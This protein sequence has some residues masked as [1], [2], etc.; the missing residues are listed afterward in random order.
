MIQTLVTGGT[1]FVGHSI[2]RELVKN[3]ESV[4]VLSRDPLKVDRARRVSGAHYIQGNVF[5]PKSL[6]RAMEGCD[7]LINCVQFENA[8]FENPKKGLTYEKVDGEGSLNQ[9][10]AIK[11]SSIERVIYMS[12]A[13]VKDG[14]IEP[15]FK[16]KL[17]AEEAVKNCGKNWTIFRPSWI[18]GAQDNSLNKFA[19]FARFSPVVPLIGMGNE[20]IQPIYVEDVAKCVAKA[21][22]TKSTF[23]EIIELG[24]QEEV[25]MKKIVQT[26]L[27]VKG[28]KRILLPHPKPLMKLIASVVQ[29]LPGRMLTPDAIDFITMEEK[30]DVSNLTR[31]LGITPLSLKEGLK[32]Y[33]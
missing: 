11:G 3:N 26:L 12:G 24:S 10:E 30:V 18:Y 9:M 15:W 21:L 17:K 13:G 16:A 4:V 27:E 20:K 5:D 7:A 31:L 23:G 33:L 32:H 25:S 29:F 1:G 14:R 8:P 6:T 28:Q 19:L 22:N 2:V